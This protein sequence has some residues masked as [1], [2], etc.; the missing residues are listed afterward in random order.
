MLCLSANLMH[1][2]AVDNSLPNVVGT[3]AVSEEER[4]ELDQILT[5]EAEETTG[6]DE[7][8]IQERISGNLFY[9]QFHAQYTIT[10][11]GYAGESVV[12][13]DGSTWTI[14]PDDA[15]MVERWN[16]N[17]N[18]KLAYNPPARI[19][20]TTNNNWYFDKAYLFR[21]YNIDTGEYAY[22]KMGHSTPFEEHAVRIDYIEYDTGRVELLGS[23]GITVYYLC[24][25]D[26]PIY[27]KWTGGQL[28]M[29][30]VNSGWFRETSTYPLM[31]IN[32]NKLTMARCVLSQ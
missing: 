4:A 17:K 29:I 6:E 13:S 22:C 8:E 20:I 16:N 24:K 10:S 31:L 9:A 25:N 32:V 14:R 2:S 12:I 26:Y 23:N 15:K 18:Y 30:G 21:M 27:S 28:M 1:A 7:Y 3:E 19:L 11:F 5:D